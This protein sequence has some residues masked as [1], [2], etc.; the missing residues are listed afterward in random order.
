ML[1]IFSD[2][3]LGGGTCEKPISPAALQLLADRLKE[4]ACN[5]FQRL[6]G[7]YQ[8]L[9]PGLCPSRIEHA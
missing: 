7:K 3:H 9:R 8:P 6:E 1:V 5:A 4:Q 2:I